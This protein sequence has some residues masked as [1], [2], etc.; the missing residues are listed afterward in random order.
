MGHFLLARDPL[1]RRTAL[2]QIWFVEFMLFD[3]REEAAS[4][5]APGGPREVPL[6]Q[7]STSGRL[8]S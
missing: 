1:R 5:R 7:W 3:P 6:E 8:C 4:D 2:S